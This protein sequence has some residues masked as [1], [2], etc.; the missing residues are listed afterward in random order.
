MATTVNDSKDEKSGGIEIIQPLRSQRALG[1]HNSLVTIEEYMYYADI[2]RKLEETKDPEKSLI[3]DFIEKLFRKQTADPAPVAHG[4]ETTN[5]KEKNAQMA[6]VGVRSVTIVSNE[7]W[8]QASR[9]GRTATW[10]AV[11]FLVTTDIMG[12]YSVPWAM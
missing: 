7:E 9:A 1:I 4:I 10:S 5:E 6:D 8:D 12:P 2:S 11:F 3:G